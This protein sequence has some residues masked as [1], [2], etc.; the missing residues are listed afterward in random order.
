MPFRSEFDDL[1]R[2]A[3]EPAVERCFGRGACV[4]GDTKRTAEV[5]SDR[6]VEAMIRSDIVI[7][8]ITGNNPNVMYEI[9]VAHSLRKP[10]LLLRSK[11]TSPPPFDLLPHERIEY[12]LPPAP[13]PEH[14]KAIQAKIEEY[15]IAMRKNPYEASSV[16]SRLLG[17][18]YHPYVDD[19]RGKRGWL[20]GYH[21]VLEL[22]TSA[23]TVWEINP[24]S[25]WLADDEAFLNQIKASVRDSS[26]KYYYLVPEEPRAVGG[27][28]RTL[29]RIA[30]MLAPADRR[31][32]DE[33]LKYVAVEPKFFELMPFSVVIYNATG[34]PKEAIL[35]EPMA[36]QIGEDGFDNRAAKVHVNAREPHELPHRWEETTFDV[37]INDRDI[38]VSLIETFRKQWNTGIDAE[39]K[40]ASAR[41]RQVL[42]DT[43]YID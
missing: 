7:G 23:K 35:L 31:R 24:D 19:F 14:F 17:Q 32:L 25:H 36:A 5:V 28:R 20:R 22:E 10:T 13:R 29:R 21:E 2:R 8:L 41:E 27:M 33:C 40:R 42:R 1:Y 26:R 38:I 11:D 16:L 3:I 37:K 6:I 18:K 4:R 12:E 30:S 15:L 9:G 34:S 39:S 43:W